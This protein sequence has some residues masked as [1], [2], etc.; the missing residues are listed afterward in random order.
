MTPPFHSGFVCLV[1]RP[2]VGKSTLVNRL[3]GRPVS[4]TSPKPQTTRQRVLGVCD[5]PAFQAVLVDTPGI[6]QARDAFNK[7]LVR[8]ALSALADADLTLLIV[9]PLSAQRPEPGPEDALVLERVRAAGAAAVLVVNKI[10]LA[11]EA[12]IL[13]TLGHYGAL[14]CFAEL[15]PVSALTGRGVERLLGL[16][17][18]HLPPGPRY[19]ED[20]QW[21]DQS[22]GALLGELVRQEVF[23]RTEQEIPYST[24]VRVEHMED[25]GDLRVVHARIFVERESQKGILIGKK[26]RMLRAIGEAARRKMESLL[27]CKI[28]LD[29]QVGV[30]ADWSRDARRM[31]QLGYPEV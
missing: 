5:H 7:R 30:L 22:E 8:Y 10:D 13:A 20:Q 19:F 3:V 1:G 28:F 24:A 29:L 14:G 17:P 16:L 26:G 11:P 23:R 9:E 4:I 15:I 27:G 25:K 2:N 31:D 6:H 12:D 18:A 21:T